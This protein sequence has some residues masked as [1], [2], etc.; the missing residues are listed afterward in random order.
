MKLGGNTRRMRGLLGYARP[1]W[2][3][4]SIALFALLMT[5]ATAIAGPV[6]AKYAIDNGISKGDMGVVELWVGIYLVVAVI[7]WLFGS[8]QN[9][10]TSWVGERMLAA[11]ARTCS[12][13][14]SRSTSATSNATAPAGS[15]RASPMTS[16]RS[17]R[18]SPTAPPR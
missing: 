6:I 3:R 1:Y 11:C 8:C 9:Y 12:G 15:S 13:T 18:W 2:F 17:T 10:L 7:G 5:T 16:R 14:C 4:G